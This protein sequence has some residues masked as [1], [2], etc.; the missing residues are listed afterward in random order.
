MVY[1]R[2]NQH[3]TWSSAQLPTQLYLAW[4]VLEKKYVECKG[5]EASIRLAKQLAPPSQLNMPL[6]FWYSCKHPSWINFRCTFCFT[7]TGLSMQCKILFFWTGSSVEL[8]R[9]QAKIYS[10]NIKFTQLKW[11]ATPT[12]DTKLTPLNKLCW[13]MCDNITFVG[14]IPTFSGKIPVIFQ[15]HPL[16]FGR[17]RMK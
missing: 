14:K 4:L 8:C 17:K 12:G 5:I 7:T 2:K 1:P 13:S 11:K 15:I 9:I 10:A 16:V 3:T 6:F